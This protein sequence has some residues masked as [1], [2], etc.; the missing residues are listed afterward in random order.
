AHASFAVGDHRRAA[1]LRLHRG[2]AEI[3]SG[4]K[5]ERSCLLQVMPQSVVALVSEYADVGC[6]LVLDLRQLRTVADHHEML[7][8]KVFER[9]DN[10]PDPFVRYHPGRRYK[11]ITFFVLVIKFPDLD[12]RVDHG[13]FASVSLPDAASDEMRIGQE[14]VDAVRRPDIPHTDAMQH[15]FDQ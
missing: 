13:S 1:R 14:M 12:R 10:H 2:D 15:P 7:V 11:K 5:D 4:S 3:L 9:F 8:P 6:G